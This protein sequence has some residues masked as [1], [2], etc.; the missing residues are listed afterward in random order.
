MWTGLASLSFILV[1][2]CTVFVLLPRSPRLAGD[3][4]LGPGWRF[5]FSPTKLFQQ[6]IDASPERSIDEMRSD[7]ALHMESN[8]DHNATGLRRLSLA[9]EVACASL[10]V[11]IVAFFAELV[12]RG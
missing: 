4:G 12:R 5:Q 2:L 3:T 1:G 9:L 7:L 8:W 11:E 6:H 10:V